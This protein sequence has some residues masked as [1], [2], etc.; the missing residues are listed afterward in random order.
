MCLFAKVLSFEIVAWK[1]VEPSSLWAENRALKDAAIP[2]N[3]TSPLLSYSPE[4]RFLTSLQS[5]ES[6]LKVV[7]SKA[8]AANRPT[9]EVEKDG[10]SGVWNLTPSLSELCMS[11]E[12]RALYSLQSWQ[13]WRWLP[14]LVQVTQFE[15]IFFRNG[16]WKWCWSI[17]FL[18]FFHLSAASLL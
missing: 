14:E 16:A 12:N 9:E 7:L 3:M 1:R 10:H 18:I 8:G 15:S 4:L 13:Q 2:L 6:S 17:S 11:P 5:S